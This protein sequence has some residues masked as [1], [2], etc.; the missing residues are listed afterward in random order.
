MTASPHPISPLRIRMIDDMRMRKV[1]VQP[2]HLARVGV[3]DEHGVH[4]N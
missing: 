1:S 2:A 3:D 4:A